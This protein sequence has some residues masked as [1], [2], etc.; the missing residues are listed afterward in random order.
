MSLVSLA[1]VPS[2]IPD[3]VSE[4]GGPT[5]AIAGRCAVSESQA[6]GGAAQ[7]TRA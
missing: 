1:S 5:P 3:D 7:Y 2:E 6:A 4:S